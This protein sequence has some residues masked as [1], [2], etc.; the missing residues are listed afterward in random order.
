VVPV[1]AVFFLEYILKSKICFYFF[2]LKTPTGTT[3]DVY[4]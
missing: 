1:L 2:F 3:V 4:L